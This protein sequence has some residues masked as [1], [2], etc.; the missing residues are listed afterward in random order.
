[1]TITLYPSVKALRL[2]ALQPYIP[3]E[4]NIPS[5]PAIQ[6]PTGQEIFTLVPP[7]IIYNSLPYI[8]LSTEIVDTTPDQVI[9]CVD[10]LPDGD[11]QSA[12]GYSFPSAATGDAVINLSNNEFWKYDGILW[13]NTG[14]APGLYL[15]GQS[16]LAPANEIRVYNC[17]VKT[18]INP[19]AYDYS[20]SVI[21]EADPISLFTRVIPLVA[22]PISIPSAVIA[23]QAF[24]P[25]TIIAVPAA[26]IN[27]SFNDIGPSLSIQRS[28]ILTEGPAPDY[29]GAFA[30]VL[31]VPSGVFL[32]AAEVPNVLTDVYL[33]VPV[34]VTSISKPNP[35]SREILRTGAASPV[36]GSGGATSY[37]DW[38]LIQNENVD[39]GFVE[40]GGFG[41]NIKINN[42]SYDRCYIGSNGYITF[43]AGFSDSGVTTTYPPY[44]KI[45]FASNDVSSQRVF[46]KQSVTAGGYK[47]FAIR[48]EGTWD[49]FGI[50]GSPTIVTEITFYQLFNNGSQYIEA[51]YGLKDLY[52]TATLAICRTTGQLG[53]SATAAANSNYVFTGNNT[54]TTWSLTSNRYIG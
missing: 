24:V 14:D 45:L 51:R 16:L 8:D 21:Q 50:I 53:N 9:G 2:D 1:M 33:S 42:V 46:K 49:T 28:Q 48:W 17:T 37:D 25:S 13:E 32:V 4:C 3:I 20:L 6:Y 47:Y 54:G 39:D 36:L 12:L 26:Q 52:F 27:L 44:A 35:V 43:G 34:S 11:E 41:F 5:V 7:G 22:Y 19:V 38:Q 15:Y 23:I 30:T 10:N 31:Q 18:K 40:S 29:V